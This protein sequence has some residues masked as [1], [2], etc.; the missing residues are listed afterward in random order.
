[1]EHPAVKSIEK[2][3]VCHILN[4]KGEVAMYHGKAIRV[5]EEVEEGNHVEELRKRSKVFVE[6]WD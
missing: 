2:V 3:A 4:S 6:W 1:M 5:Y